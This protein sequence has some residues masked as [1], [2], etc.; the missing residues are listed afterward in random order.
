MKMGN[1]EYL[2]KAMQLS[3]EE[4]ERLLARMV[5]KLPRRLEK[6]KLSREEALAIQMELED[7][8]LQ[9]WREKMRAIQEKNKDQDEREAK[10][11]TKKS[12]K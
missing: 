3:E 1:P 11:G 10:S 6:E 7:E 8:Q 5:G 4:Q 9:E 12:K 2:A